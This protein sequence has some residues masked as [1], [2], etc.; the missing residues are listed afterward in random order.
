M[1]TFRKL[2]LPLGILSNSLFLPSLLYGQSQPKL[3]LDLSH[4]AAHVSPR[5]YGLMTEEINYSYDGG[6]YGELVRNRAFRDHGDKTDHWFLVKAEGDSSSMKLDTKH[7]VNM[8]LPVS[9]HLKTASASSP[10]GI[11]ND[12]FWG[13]P[14]K[15]S[16]TYKGSFY[17]LTENTSEAGITASIESTD[18]KTVYAK[19]E[20]TGVGN[21]WKKFIYTLT[22]AQT[23]K[24][25]ADTRLVLRPKTAGSYFFSLVSLFPPTFNNKAN[26]NRPDIMQLLAD[27]RPSFLRLPGGNYLEGGMFS[28]RF[29][30]KKTLGPIDHRPGHMGTWGYRSSDGMGLLEYLEWC[31]DLHMEPLLAVFAGYALN[32]DYLEKGPLLKPFVDDALEEIEYV[33]GDTTTV[34]GKKRAQDGHPAPFPLH[35]VEV[36]NEDGFDKSTSYNGRFEQFA[37]AIKAKYPNLQVIAT[38]GGKDWLGTRYAFDASKADVVDEHYYRNAFEMESDADHYDNYD[39]KGPKIFVGE[40]ATREGS[41][42]PNFNSALGDAAW[43]T[44]MERNSDIVIMSCSAPL[45]VNVN[46]GGMQWASD[47]IGYNTLSS[48]GSPSYYA[49]QMFNNNKGDEIIAVHGEGIPTQI[50]K[51]NH[52][53]S[54]ASVKPKTYPGLFYVATRD[55]K[56]GA[57]YLK[58]VNCLPTAQ[59]IDFN[60]SGATKV[61][62]AAKVITM[63]ADKPEDTNTITDPRRI[64]PVNSKFNGVKSSFN[65]AFAP[66][67]ITILQLETK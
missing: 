5:L 40:W 45:F 30:W 2:L 52:K 22:T 61:K 49:Q 3:T 43:M 55:S 31:E 28:T 10:A 20:I 19:A 9:L 34:W 54:L 14:V 58:V 24:P 6:I 15:P 17:A 42:T 51:L 21:S 27:M 8:A 66:Y 1:L 36:G 46:P 63:K 32:G 7:P 37:D 4:A 59:K 13:I 38:M 41:P 67:S 65:Y 50:Q 16:T 11:A 60:L 57:V 12:G 48:Y 53:D 35:Y 64:V 26:G 44:G 47:L 56:T 39:R 18:G 33:T 62:P 29:D 25:T 23:A